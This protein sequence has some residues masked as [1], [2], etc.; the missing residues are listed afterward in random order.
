MVITDADA[1]IARLTGELQAARSETSGLE[2]ELAAMRHSLTWRLTEPLRR[3][4]G[5]LRDLSADRNTVRILQSSGLFD[6]DYYRAQNPDV[7]AAFVDPIRHYVRYG[8]AEG[9]NPSRFFETLAYVASH[10]ELIHS[11]MNSLL[12]YVLREGNKRLPGSK[13]DQ[14]DN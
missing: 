11:G 4:A 7:A 9:R 10:P 13:G 5:W 1:E 6:R 2:R 14:D 3:W 12:H 8:A